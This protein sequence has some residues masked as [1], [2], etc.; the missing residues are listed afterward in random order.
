MKWSILVGLPEDQQRAVLASCTRRKYAKG[1]TLFHEGDPGSTLHLLDTGRVAVRVLT[2]IGEV[3]TLAV[4]RS[5]D[6][7][8]EQALLDE[9]STRSASIVA[10]EAVETLT[11][12]QRDFDQL[13]RHHPT[14]ERMLV[15]LLAAQVRRLSIS[16]TE[17]LYLPAEKRVL[18]R[19]IDLCA[20][21]RPASAAA[22]SPVVI[23]LTQEDLATMAGTTR[24]TV[25]R[26]LQD[27]VAAGY[28]S[29]GRGRIEVTDAPSL[30]RSPRPLSAALSNELLTGR[31][32]PP[33]RGRAAGGGGGAGCRSRPGRSGCPGAGGRA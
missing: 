5:G 16:L 8:G 21:Y 18:R 33:S 27:A 30:A 15:V 13:R 17:A 31:R 25:N 12:H 24:P 1:D 3:A 9:G 7:F 23:A 26:T 2:P 14:V 32:P 11:L 29:L 19:L 28:V 4:L 6:V 10:L 20:V 22:D